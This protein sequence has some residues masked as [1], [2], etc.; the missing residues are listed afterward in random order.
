MS[1]HEQEEAAAIE[2]LNKQ[3]EQLEEAYRRKRN[4]AGKNPEETEENLE[5]ARDEAV[6]AHTKKESHAV[7]DL[8]GD[9]VWTRDATGHGVREY[10][11]TATVDR[12]DAAK[13]QNERL[14]ELNSG[15]VADKDIGGADNT[16]GGVGTKTRLKP[17]GEEAEQT[18]AV[19]GDETTIHVSNQGLAKALQDAGVKNPNKVAHQLLAQANMDEKH[20]PAEFRV[21]KEMLGELP[22]QAM[23]ALSP[24]EAGK[25]NSLA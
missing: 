8:N 6:K 13:D 22:P 24:K 4:A 25:G 19:S 18:S 15:K 11:E 12:Y 5:N 23:A 14:K 3:N 10:R 2:K 7:T 20:V 17:E 9:P 21:S 16:V 1:L